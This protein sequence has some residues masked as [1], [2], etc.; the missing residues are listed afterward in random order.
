MA[1]SSAHAEARRL[2]GERLWR[3]LL[4]PDDEDLV[5]GATP[6]ATGAGATQTEVRGDGARSSAS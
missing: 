3:W 1:P 4:R 6:A 2:A 5:K